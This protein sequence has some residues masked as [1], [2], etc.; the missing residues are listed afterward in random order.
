MI[1][2]QDR[3]LERKA[4]GS[5]IA[6]SNLVYE[7]KLIPE[8]FYNNQNKLMFEVILEIKNKDE[9]IDIVSVSSEINKKNNN[10]WLPSDISEL[11]EYSIFISSIESI[12]RELILLYEKRRFLE[13]VNNSILKLGEHEDFELIKSELFNNLEGKISTDIPI[14][15]IGECAEKAIEI[16]EEAYKNGGRITGMQS[17]YQRLDAIINGF[18]KPCYMV[19]GARPGVGKT[20]FSLELAR[21]LSENNK[22]L[23]FSLE[24]PFEQL[25]QRVLAN[26]SKIPLA[27]IKKGNIEDKAFNSLLGSAG[28]LYKNNCKVV[29]KENLRIEDLVSICKTYQR[30]NGLDGIVIDYFT[31]LKSYKQFRD[32]RLL[33]NYISEEIRMLAKRLKINIILL[34]QC[35]RKADDKR[36][37]Q[38]SDLKET[39]NLEQ[40]ANIVMFL[41]QKDDT[42]NKLSGEPREDYI[43]AT[44]RKNR[45]GENN[46]EIYFRYYKSTQILDEDRANRIKNESN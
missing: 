14:V 19:I 42:T 40:D 43:R 44:I 22:I 11:L 35:N 3:E 13:L 9:K 46:M 26:R 6:D 2:Y 16:T 17:G 4:L 8:Y 30:K 38:L 15:S 23:Y 21:R 31:L 39:A 32:S 10:K 33:Y 45:S 34:A 37:L 5:Y 36:E 29:E 18:E 27:K 41:E 25:G 24:M 12:E 28:E 7:S 1:Q 20:A